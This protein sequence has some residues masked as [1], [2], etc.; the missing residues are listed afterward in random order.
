MTLL[1]TVSVALRPWTSQQLLSTLIG[2]TLGLAAA[3]NAQAVAVKATP[4]LSK[5]DTERGYGVAPTPAWVVPDA[6]SASLGST[7]DLPSITPGESVAGVVVLS[8]DTQIKVS[9][10]GKDSSQTQFRRIVRQINTTAGLEEGAQWQVEFDPT[11]ERLVIH[12]MV[13]WRGQQRMDRLRSTSLKILHRETQLER[14]MIDGRM[15]ASVVLPDIRVGDRIELAFSIEGANPVYGGRFAHTEWMSSVHGPLVWA[16]LRVVAPQSRPIQFRADAAG[17]FHIH[18]A[19]LANARGLGAG[20]W[21]EWVAIREHVPQ[22]P[23][24][25]STPATEW[26]P[27][28]IDATEFSDWSDVGRWAYGLFASR[29]EPVAPE[30]DAQAQ[31]LKR[32]SLEATATAVLDFVQN[33]IRYFGSED[34]VNSHQPA[35]PE[36]VLQQRFGDCKDKVTLFVALLKQLQ[37]HARPVL[38]SATYHGAALDRKPTPLAFDHVIVQVDL[39]GRTYLLD[40]TR[41]SQ[42]GPLAEREVVGWGRGL[43]ADVNASAPIDL[44][45]ADGVLRFVGE[46]TL[47]FSRIS[48]DP[49][50][51]SQW[52]Y[53]RE[54]ADGLRAALASGHEQ[55]M[56]IARYIQSL[57]AA[58]FRGATPTGE[59]MVQEVEGHDAITLR[60][61]YTVSNYLRLTQNLHLAADLGL[62][63]LQ[64]SLRLPD[65]A[66]RGQS[67]Q[68]ALVGTYKQRLRVVVPEAIWPAV[69]DRSQSDDG[70]AYVRVR[71]TLER[72]QKTLIMEGNLTVSQAI[73]PA[74]DWTAHRDTL[75]QLW[76]RLSTT[77]GL[78]TLSPARADK[79]KSDMKDLSVRIQKGTG[80]KLWSQ[81]LNVLIESM[82]REAQ[83]D[84]GRLPPQAEA[85]IRFA[86]AVNQDNLGKPFDAL[87]HFRKVLAA[88]PDSVEV[89]NALAVNAEARQEDEEAVDW[90]A[91]VLALHA[92]NEEALA[93]SAHALYFLGRYG[94][95]QSA[96][97]NAMKTASGA[98]A[99][100]VA[101]WQAMAAKRLGLDVAARLAPYA[102]HWSTDWPRPVLD[103]FLQ[104]MSPE[105]ARSAAAASGDEASGQLCELNFYLGEWALMEGKTSEADRLFK[106]SLETNAAGYIEFMGA[107][108]RLHKEK[109]VTLRNQ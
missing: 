89:L 109:K 57:Y 94:D 27:D 65:Q 11:Y 88:R 52:T 59:L 1:R 54:Q 85:D 61:T 70:D 41:S 104:R 74:K 76:P 21:H 44:P 37:I 51:T 97:D 108:R 72:Q 53:Y 91:K 48:R 16:R 20:A 14:Q 79:L 103:V 95:S 100:Y 24:A 29:L 106:Q 63:T 38:V 33:E 83:L 102:S 46:D 69:A 49:I 42:Q 62:V 71:S 40:A 43:L 10:L 99:V 5:V 15:T 25:P 77:Q 92:D 56:A 47:E 66:P 68:L 39:N 9:G 8:D 50:L 86:L 67:L 73:L 87:P 93:T 32:D 18:E 80:P 101:L 98:Q 34:G 2:L 26:L 55:R 17:G 78:P 35:P 84:E 28:Q 19:D 90:G 23:M 58:Q 7:K 107:A 30:V 64:D 105:Q 22:F 4:P 45:S 75:Q 12:S 82:I 60:Q 81:G 6:T 36:K 96:L 3:G 13:V 31:A